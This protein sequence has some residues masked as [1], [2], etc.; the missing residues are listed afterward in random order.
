MMPK[1]NQKVAL[2]AYNA[3][4]T[5]FHELNASI[6]TCKTCINAN[7]TNEAIQLLDCMQKSSSKANDLTLGAIKHYAKIDTKE[8]ICKKL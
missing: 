3:L 1:K 2:Q 7:M 8:W 5:F 6:E 4:F